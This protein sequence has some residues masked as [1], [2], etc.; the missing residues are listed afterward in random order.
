MLIYFSVR[1]KN[2]ALVIAPS[3]LTILGYTLPWH[4]VHYAFIKNPI[5]LEFRFGTIKALL[6]K[7][8]TPSKVVANACLLNN[9]ILLLLGNAS[10]AIYLIHVIV[11]YLLIDL[12]QKSDTGKVISHLLPPDA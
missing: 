12:L 8:Y 3:F 1:K 2:V 9:R 11:Q 6:Y 10:Y 4:E 7:Q 5:I